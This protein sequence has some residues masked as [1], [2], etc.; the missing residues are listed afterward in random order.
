MNFHVGI[1]VLMKY[2]CIFSLVY[3]AYS[4]L[5]LKTAVC[6]DAILFLCAFEKQNNNNFIIS[7]RLLAS[8]SFILKNLFNKESIGPNYGSAFK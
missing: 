2:N 7:R 6:K 4:L 1:W 3:I 8:E 5:F